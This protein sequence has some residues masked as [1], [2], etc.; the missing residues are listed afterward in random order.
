MPGHDG[1]FYGIAG[2]ACSIAAIVFLPPLYGIAGLAFGILAI[3]KGEALFG[4]SAVVLAALGMMV[5]IGLL[6][7]TDA[8]PE[9]MYIKKSEPEHVS[10]K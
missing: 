6:L 8:H 10:P 3:K 4:F 5:G 7:F 9:F 1:T 2:I